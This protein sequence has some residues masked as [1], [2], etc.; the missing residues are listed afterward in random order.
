MTLEV[1]ASRSAVLDPDSILDELARLDPHLNEEAYYSERALFYNPGRSVPLGVIFAAVKD[2][3]G[4]NDKRSRLSRPEVFRFAF[5]LPRPEYERRFGR[6]PPRPAKG[7]VVTIDH[8]PSVLDELTPH[9]VYA[10]MRWVQ[11]LCPTR[12]AFDSLLPPLEESLASVRARWD[13]RASSR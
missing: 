3:D 11:I 8:D 2:H 10:W 6:P 9:P 13:A 5:Q 1:A 4:P 7:E 12:P